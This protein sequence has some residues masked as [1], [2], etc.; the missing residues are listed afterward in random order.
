MVNY[1]GRIIKKNNEIVLKI[2][3]E[4]KENKNGT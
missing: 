3:Q 4:I 2:S 1:L